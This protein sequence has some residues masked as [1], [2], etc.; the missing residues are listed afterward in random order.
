MQQPKYKQFELT[1][2]NGSTVV[3]SAPTSKVTINYAANVAYYWAKV[4]KKDV[5]SVKPIK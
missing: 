5:I 1:L 4:S 2:I 3:C